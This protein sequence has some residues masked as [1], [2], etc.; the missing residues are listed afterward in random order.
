MGNSYRIFSYVGVA[1]IVLLLIGLA[2]WYFFLRNQASNLDALGDSR[3][4]D[5]AVPSFTGSR[6][7]TAENIEAG[8]SAE[9]LLAATP[10]QG[11]P[12]RLWKV[13]SSPIAGFGFVVDSSNIRYIERSTGYVYDVNPET[14]ATTRLTKELI[15][16]VYEGLIVGTST[17]VMR[18]LE[19][20]EPTT[21][22][23]RFGTSTNDGFVVF[24]TSNL[25]NTIRTI[26]SSANELMMLASGANGANL[27]R[28]RGDGTGAQQILTLGISGFGIQ[29][30]PDGRLFLTE[31][32][33]S[34]VAGTAYE[35]VQGALTPVLRSLPGLLIKPRT[36][37]PALL[38]SIDDG[39]RVRLFARPSAQASTTELSI[40]TVA[41]KCVWAPSSSSTPTLAAYCA[42][43]Q[44]A[45][46]RNFL[47]NW[48]RGAIHT[49]DAWFTIDASAAKSSK[50]FAPETTVALDVEKPL[51]DSRGGFIAFM[52][53]RDKSLWVLRIAE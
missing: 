30:L 25:G 38:Y 5:I 24:S 16:K 3:G 9:S 36:S 22:I 44:T 50:F 31:S 37:S 12:P 19:S 46:P 4:F 7:S 41:E 15:P 6:S 10:N 43:P 45:L 39:T 17:V 20:G 18:T 32:P 21:L 23:G 51:I 49:S 34:G 28:A 33:A 52:N 35:V 11:R 26:T 29:W 8:T 40:Q 47:D 42:S 48:L 14:G 2:G 27:V 53:A 1:A 13:S